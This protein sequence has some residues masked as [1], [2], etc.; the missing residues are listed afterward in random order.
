MIEAKVPQVGV[1]GGR[2]VSRVL[3][4]KVLVQGNAEYKGRGSAWVAHTITGMGLG[5]FWW[6]WWWYW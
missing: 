1:I 5:L 3:S 6:W 4:R 2:T